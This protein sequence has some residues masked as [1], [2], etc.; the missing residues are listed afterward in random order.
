MGGE[1]E[2]KRQLKKSLISL[3]EWRRKFGISCSGSRSDYR[4]R[5]D[6]SVP[7]QL[8]FHSVAE[9]EQPKHQPYGVEP[10]LSRPRDFLLRKLTQETECSPS[11]KR[12]EQC[13]QPLYIGLFQLN[14]E[15]SH[16]PHHYNPKAE[17]S[18]NGC[19][20]HEFIRAPRG[21][22]IVV[23]CVKRRVSC[24]PVRKGGVLSMSCPFAK[25]AIL[26]V[27]AQCEINNLRVINTSSRFNSVPGHHHFKSS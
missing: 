13:G 21:V 9:D 2:Y 10:K 3:S 24:R 23:Q 6:L 8:F 5:E 26:A 15:Q 20:I 7:L 11:Q 17:C 16:K 12:R 18:D 1:S 25:R 19:P 14:C 4:K 22:F 27:V